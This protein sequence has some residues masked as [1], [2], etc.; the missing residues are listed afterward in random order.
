MS[1]KKSRSVAAAIFVVAASINGSIRNA[2]A[3]DSFVSNHGSSVPIPANAYGN[4]AAKWW[5]WAFA[6]RFV[7]FTKG[8]VDCAAGQSGRVWFLAGQLV[9]EPDVR[10]CRAPIPLGTTLFFPLVNYGFW[11][12]DSNCPAQG[13]SVEQKRALTNGFFSDQVP[14]ALNSYA[15]QLSVVVDDV[16]VQNNGY[17]IVRTQ[18]PVFP[19]NGT[20]PDGTKVSD[21][22]TIDDGYYVA[23]PPL[24]RGSHMIH[25]SG[26]LCKFG[27]SPKSLTQKDSPK[28]PIFKVD[29]KYL[30]E[31]R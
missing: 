28:A 15:C 3:D 18:S 21:S 2:R 17:G 23:I 1:A 16:P 7:Q 8:A 9:P 13:C 4:W 5:Q 31:V 25:F 10:T 20:L 22:Q 12:P 30:F 29:V 6:S 26:G 24:A 19:L 27:H 14:G 11:N